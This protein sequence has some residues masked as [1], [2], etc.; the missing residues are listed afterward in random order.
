MRIAYL[1]CFS[2]MS[3]DMFLGALIDAGVSPEVFE[4]AVAALKVGARLEI[5]KVNRSGITATKVDVL[6]NGEKE[7]P[8]ES[9]AAGGHGHSHSHEHHEHHEHLEHTHAE[10]HAHPHSHSQL[11][12]T[13][14]SA[15]H[16]HGR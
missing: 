11:S 13:G 15:P 12:R 10:A 7:M 5:T 4:K 9:V 2:G 3:G 1:E 16:S 6:V 8:S 14:V